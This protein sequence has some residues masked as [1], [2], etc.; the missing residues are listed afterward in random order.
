MP[1]NSGGAQFLSCPNLLKN[2]PTNY[3]IFYLGN[4]VMDSSGNFVSGKDVMD[5]IDPV[6][7]GN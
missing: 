4:G 1:C 5:F 7:H 3:P 2:N 6:I